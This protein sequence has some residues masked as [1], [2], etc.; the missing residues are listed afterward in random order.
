MLTTSI[1]GP[2]QCSKVTKKQEVA[3]VP[4]SSQNDVCWQVA[5]IVAGSC[6]QVMG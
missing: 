6:G 2:K 4:P 5:A 1:A 3:L